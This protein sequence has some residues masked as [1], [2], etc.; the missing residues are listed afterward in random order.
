[1]QLVLFLVHRKSLHCEFCLTIV[2]LSAPLFARELMS[3]VQ[4]QSIGVDGDGEY[5]EGPHTM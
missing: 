4:L 1:M 2:D 5:W 3:L